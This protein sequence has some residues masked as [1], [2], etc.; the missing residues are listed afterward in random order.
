MLGDDGDDLVYMVKLLEKW[1][2]KTSQQKLNI[3]KFINAHVNCTATL[4][5]SVI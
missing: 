3:S 1:V 5:N 4:L 2:F